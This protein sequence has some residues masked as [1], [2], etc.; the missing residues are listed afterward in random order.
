MLEIGTPEPPGEQLFDR[1]AFK[2][3]LP[4]VSRAR[5]EQTLLP[6]YPSLRPY[7]EKLER[8][9]T[10]QTVATLS[11]IWACPLDDARALAAQLV[12][13][14]FFERRV[15]PGGEGFW[16]PFVY[17]DALQLVQGTEGGAVGD[18]SDEEDLEDD[19]T[20]PSRTVPGR[21]ATTPRARTGQVAWFVALLRRRYRKT[22]PAVYSGFLEADAR[23]RIAAPLHYE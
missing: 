5:L 17:R 4:A 19:E 20:P 14:G 12:E 6:E 10:L 15:G 13:V 23:I 9:K 21:R 1:A 22:K 2:T 8:R 7:V 16:V 11:E 3:A 18:S